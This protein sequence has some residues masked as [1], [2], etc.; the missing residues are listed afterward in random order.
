MAGSFCNLIPQNLTYLEQ[1]R[2]LVLFLLEVLDKNSYI[3]KKFRSEKHI[4]GV[5]GRGV[6]I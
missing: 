5:G 2:C 4:F 3:L 6:D 1:N